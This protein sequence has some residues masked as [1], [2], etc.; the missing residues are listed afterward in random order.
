M[1]VKAEQLLFS[2]VPHLNRLKEIRSLEQFHQVWN[3]KM[4]D[5]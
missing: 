2:M 4:G 5:S 1:Q 3:K